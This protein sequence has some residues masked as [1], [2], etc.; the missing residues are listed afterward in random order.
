MSENSTL[1]IDFTEAKKIE[2]IPQ[3]VY[4]ITH[5]KARR[6][7]NIWGFAALSPDDSLSGPCAL[8][9]LLYFHAIGWNHL[10]REQNGRPVNNRYVEE[11]TRWSK[12]PHLLA[13]S[14]STTPNMMQASLRKAGLRA[15]WYAGSTVEKTLL[16]TRYEIA[17]GHPVIVLLNR[18]DADEAVNLEWQVVFKI[19]ETS[20]YT[21]HC[22][23]EDAEMTW[24]IE[25]F[26]RCLQMNLKALSCSVI[27]AE[28]D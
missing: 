1:I 27:T 28:K 10:P 3:H 13:G 14:M 8:G 5:H 20:V 16:L 21:K 12:T 22:A 6:L 17:L 4:P 24:S 7:Q 15:Q 11:L 25:E 9:T 23:Y 2:N 26:G 18:S 19:S